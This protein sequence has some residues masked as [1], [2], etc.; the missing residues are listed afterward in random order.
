M[1]KRTRIDELEGAERLVRQRVTDGDQI[2]IKAERCADFILDKGDEYLSERID[3]MDCEA[4]KGLQEVFVKCRYDLDD[5]S[6]KISPFF[7]A[8]Y[9]SQLNDTIRE[10]EEARG[11]ILSAFS[12]VYAKGLTSE[13]GKKISHSTLNKM[14]TDRLDAIKEDEKKQEDRAHLEATYQAKVAELERQ[15]Q[16]LSIK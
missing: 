10:A 7:E 14:L 13:T 16:A 3:G 11:I 15:V 8:Y 4:V 6:M 2:K 1:V 12:V 9:V 5:I